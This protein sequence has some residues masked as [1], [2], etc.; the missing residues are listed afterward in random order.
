MK[1]SGAFSQTCP[2]D[3][4]SAA[5]KSWIIAVINFQKGGWETSRRQME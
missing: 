5:I 3:A 4:K 1:C 2:A